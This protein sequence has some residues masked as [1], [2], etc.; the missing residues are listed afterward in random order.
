MLFALLSR[1]LASRRGSR[2]PILIT[3]E[4]A[5]SRRMERG[6]CFAG[7]LVIA[8]LGLAQ[9]FSCGRSEHERRWELK[10]LYAGEGQITV[11]SRDRK[12]GDGPCRRHL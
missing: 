9:E 6:S 10:K 5:A 4:A 11:R 7:L 8:Q 1:R 12:C 2:R 3:K